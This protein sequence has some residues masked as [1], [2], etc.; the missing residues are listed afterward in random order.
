[1]AT[2]PPPNQKPSATLDEIVH[3][4]LDVA[5][6]NEY[7]KAI[8]EHMKEVSKQAESNGREVINKDEMG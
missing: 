4:E 1:M 6:K 3:E 2:N 7:Y 5:N 8:A